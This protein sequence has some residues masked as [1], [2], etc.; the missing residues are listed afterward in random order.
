MLSSSAIVG[1]AGRLPLSLGRMT[2]ADRAI[3]VE[4]DAHRLDELI[5]MWRASFE[6][7]VGVIDPHPLSEQ[8]QYFLAEVLPRTVVCLAIHGDA[9][10]GFIAASAESVAQ[11]YVRVD[12]Q[13]RGV[14]AQLLTWPKERSTGKLWLYTYTRNLGARAFY[15]RNG[16]VAIAHGLEPMLQLDDIKYQWTVGTHNAG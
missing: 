1:A 6:A 3:L 11:L 15:E 13:R 2:V 10:V 4:F 16:F 12:C 7:G 9:I 14:G 8:R 5:H